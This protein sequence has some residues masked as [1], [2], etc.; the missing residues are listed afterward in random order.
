MTREAKSRY[1]YKAVWT[2]MSQTEQTA[3]AQVIG[4]VDDVYML[5][6]AQETRRWLEESVGV[7]PDDI[8]LEI[9]CGIGRV[10]LALA[11]R[12]KQWIGCD[13]SPNM[14]EFARERLA[15]FSNVQFVELSGF[16]LRPIQS[17]SVDL[18][19]CTVVFMHLDEWDRYNYILEAYR[20]LRPGGRI[21]VDNFNLCSDEGWGV[22]EAVRQIAPKSRP[23]AISKSSTPQEIEVYLRRAG[24]EDIRVVEEQTW[25]RGY[26]VKPADAD[27]HAFEPAPMSSQAAQH[28]PAIL[29]EDPHDD[30]TAALRQRIEALE[31]LIDRK[32]QHILYLENLLRKIESGRVMRLL[33]RITRS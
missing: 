10:G 13:V 21:F 3:R 28:I 19:Y 33:R 12:C 16:D 29:P 27:T 26:G 20:V 4:D 18:V 15:A 8:I 7:K 24:F 17:G 32:D 9:G 6:T 23:P 31:A 14:L 30:G 11:P 2:A 22:F 25:V 5:E 1:E